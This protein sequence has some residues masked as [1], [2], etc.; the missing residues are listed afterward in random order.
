MAQ[1]TEIDLRELTDL[2]KGLG[3]KI[4]ALD[5]R[6]VET[7]KQIEAL[8]KKMDLGFQALDKKIDLKFADTDAKIEA[9]SKKTELSFSEVNGKLDLVDTR[10]TISDSTLV[11]LD[12]RLWS[13]G[14]IAL[15][16]TL[17]SLL[18]V[19]ARYIFTDS[20]KF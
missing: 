3:S 17:G 16:V 2:V 11:K 14:G 20:P 10:L 6:F 1:R 13:F 8:D 19:F 12:N 5:K 9:L 4:E 18:T 7:D 15:S